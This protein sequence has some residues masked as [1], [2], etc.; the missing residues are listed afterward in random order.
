MSEESRAV[1]F[2]NMHIFSGQDSERIRPLFDEMDRLRARVAEL[3]RQLA[4]RD[5]TIAELGASNA[6]LLAEVDRLKVQLSNYADDRDEARRERDEAIAHDRQ[7]YPTAEAYSAAVAALD[8]HRQRA[9][10]LV[11]EMRQLR[12]LI[13]RVTAA[14]IR[15][16]RIE[17]DRVAVYAQTCGR[18]EVEGWCPKHAYGTPP[19]AVDALSTSQRDRQEA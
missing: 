2:D 5:R 11:D 3:E 6:R 12:D 1:R 10:A 15:E 17:P 8:H 16:S 14:A 18:A 13:D 4:S 7:P 19:P 9:D